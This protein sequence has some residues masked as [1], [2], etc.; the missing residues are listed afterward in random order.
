[1][2]IATDGVVMVRIEGPLEHTLRGGVHYTLDPAPYS[3]K[4]GPSK[5]TALIAVEEVSGPLPFT[6]YSIDERAKELGSSAIDPHRLAT[7][8]KALS[9]LT[10]HVEIHTGANLTQLKVRGGYYGID[11][12]VRAFIANL[13]MRK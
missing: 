5:S 1:M 3:K 13:D 10:N 8:S 2:T 11:F 9:A 12:E 4:P 6:P 7:A